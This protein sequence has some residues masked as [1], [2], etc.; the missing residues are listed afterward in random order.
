MTSVDHIIID[1]VF[2]AQ[3]DELQKLVDGSHFSAEL[4]KDVGLLKNRFL[5]GESH[6]AGKQR[7]VMMRWNTVSLMSW[8]ILWSIIFWLRR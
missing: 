7:W 1:A 3:L 4:L 5:S 2:Y 8:W 6:S